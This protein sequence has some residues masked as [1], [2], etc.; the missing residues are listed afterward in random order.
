MIKKIFKL[1]LSFGLLTPIIVF[2][3]RYNNVSDLFEFFTNLI[4]TAIIPVLVGLALVYFL[5][6]AGLFIKNADDTSKRSEGRMFMLY[7][8]IGLFVIIAIWG[9]VQ[10]LL[11]TFGIPL[12]S[13]RF[14]V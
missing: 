6:G 11:G 3:A 4:N 7:G 8:V 2:A 5:W 13:P 9:L 1:V 14:P 10:V 12:V